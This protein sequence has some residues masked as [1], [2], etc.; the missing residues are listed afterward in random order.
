M[1]RVQAR[2]GVPHPRDEGVGVSR[3][4]LRHQDMEPVRRRAR[5]PVGLT[6]VLA[7]DGA[8]TGCVA[9]RCPGPHHPQ[10]HDEDGSRV[11]IPSDAGRLMVECRIPIRPG[12][13]RHPSADGLQPFR[14]RDAGLGSSRPSGWWPLEKRLQAFAD[15]L[16]LMIGGQ[17]EPSAAACPAGGAS[18]GRRHVGE[19]GHA[20][21]V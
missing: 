2:A 18:H 1:P 12:I 4:G 17:D 6:G 7:H 14:A 3:R 10:T 15:S 13:H 11:S 21:R 8:D 9:L 16:I 5:D 19:V 20:R